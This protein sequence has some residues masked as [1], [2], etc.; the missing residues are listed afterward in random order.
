LSPINLD[1]LAVLV[2]FSVFEVTV[3]AR[4]EADVDREI[5]DLQ[6]PALLSAVKDLKDAIKIAF[7]RTNLRVFQDRGTL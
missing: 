3:R 5:A 4:T 1:N 6:H 7:H 2:L